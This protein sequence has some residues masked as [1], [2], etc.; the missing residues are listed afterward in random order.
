ME[1]SAQWMWRPSITSLNP[2]QRDR[3]L[4]L[5]AFGTMAFGRVVCR[6]SSGNVSGPISSSVDILLTWMNLIMS[7]GW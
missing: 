3:V 4:W 5:C 1:R 6:T 2:C 7:S